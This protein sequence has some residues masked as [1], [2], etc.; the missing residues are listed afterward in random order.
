MTIFFIWNFQLLRIK[1]CAFKQ[2]FLYKKVTKTNILLC[3]LKPFKQKVF[4]DA[5]CQFQWSHLQ[6]EEQTKSIICE[7]KQRATSGGLYGFVASSPR[8][9]AFVQRTTDELKKLTWWEWHN[10]QWRHLDGAIKCHARRQH[11]APHACALCHMQLHAG[12]SLFPLFLSAFSG[13]SAL[14]HSG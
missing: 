7:R 12:I 11:P 9:V 5:L 6:K 1:S 3:K 14:Y 2:K 13:H 10:A 8:V 4:I